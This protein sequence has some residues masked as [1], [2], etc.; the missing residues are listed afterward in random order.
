MDASAQRLQIILASFT[1]FGLAGPSRVA[2][3]SSPGLLLLEDILL[4]PRHFQVIVDRM[5]SVNIAKRFLNHL[6][7]EKGVDLAFQYNVSRIHLE[8][9]FLV[10]EMGVVNNCLC[11]LFGEDI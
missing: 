5:N 7:F 9:H 2:D 8:L 10:I 6:F 1:F 4:V 11:D 3:H